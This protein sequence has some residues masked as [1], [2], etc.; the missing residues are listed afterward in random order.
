VYGVAVVFMRE[1]QHLLMLGSVCL[2]MKRTIARIMHIMPYGGKRAHPYLG[3][4]WKM[5]Q[6][7]ICHG[8]CVDTQVIC[9]PHNQEKMGSLQPQRGM[10]AFCM[11]AIMLLSNQQAPTAVLALQG[12]VVADI[13]TAHKELG[14]QIP[15]NFMGISLEWP[16]VHHYANNTER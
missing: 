11:L 9:H 4:E 6:Y 14:K 7:C 15:L 13:R 12:S 5:Q 2:M 3:F 10:K 16:A 1:Q 8:D